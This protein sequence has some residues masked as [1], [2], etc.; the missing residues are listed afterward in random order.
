[1]TV[2]VSVRYSLVLLKNLTNS[3]P[4]LQN[5]GHWFPVTACYDMRIC[6]HAVHLVRLVIMHVNRVSTATFLLPYSQFLFKLSI[7]HRG[8]WIMPLKDIC[9][10]CHA[11]RP[12]HVFVHLRIS[13]CRISNLTRCLLS[14]YCAYPETTVG[15]LV[16]HNLFVSTQYFEAPYAWHGRYIRFLLFR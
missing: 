6:V 15:L 12:R 16:P 5:R 4:S 10:S 14:K 8:L 1:M 9:F 3:S 11:N 2:S 13:A 7:H